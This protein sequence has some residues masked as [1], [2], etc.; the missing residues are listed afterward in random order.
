M[1]SKQLFSLLTKYAPISLSDDLCKAENGYDNSGIIIGGDKQ[2]DSVL[3]VLDLT[4]K[5]VDFAIEN[6][7][8]IIVTHHPAIYHPIKNLLSDT[9]LLRCANNNISVISMHLN[10]DCAEKGIDYYLAQGLGGKIVKILNPLGENV[11]YGR[12]SVLN[13]TAGELL[14]RYKTVFE[15]EK[16]LLY[17]DANTKITKVASFC[18]AGLGD[19]EIDEAV[20]EGADMVVSADIPHHVLISAIEK[21][22]CVLSCTHYSSENYGMKKFADSFRD[23]INEKIYF[24]GDDRFV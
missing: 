15:T 19:R 7:C 24:F 23:K 9:T 13:T 5:A 2:T 14:K 18:G 3:F 10:L 17:G 16:V 1:N 20:N 8:G 6:K 4:S 12:L 21:G 11:G 22:L